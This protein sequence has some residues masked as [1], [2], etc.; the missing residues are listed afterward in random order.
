MPHFYYLNSA[1]PLQV[2]R[3]RSTLDTIKRGYF[4]RFFNEKLQKWV[5]VL[6]KY[7]SITMKMFA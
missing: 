4:L 6:L 3:K 1:K 2:A 7:A 5:M